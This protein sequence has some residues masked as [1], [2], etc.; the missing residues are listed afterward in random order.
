[1][2]FIVKH[3]FLWK[4]KGKNPYCWKLKCTAQHFYCSVTELAY[5]PCFNLYN[6]W[7][8]KS[9][10]IYWLIFYSRG[11]TWRRQQ[12]GCWRLPQLGQTPAF[13]SIWQV[14]WNR[15]DGHE[16]SD[17]GQGKMYNWSHFCCW[18][19]AQVQRWVGLLHLIKGWF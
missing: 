8:W 18:T 14:D 6:F 11:P 1:M 7:I 10:N 5:H 15:F 9:K 13:V 4:F 17:Q 16:N 2:H 3:I 12:R 19:L